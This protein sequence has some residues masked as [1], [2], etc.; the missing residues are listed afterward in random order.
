MLRIVKVKIAHNIQKIN[1]QIKSACN[2]QEKVADL[3]EKM[4][5][6]SQFKPAWWLKSAHAQTILP[7]LM[8]RDIVMDLR[9]ERLSMTDGDFVDLVWAEKGLSQQS[10]LIILLHGLGGNIQ[11][12]YVKGL[13]QQFNRHGWRAVLM[14]FRGCSGVPNR[15][16]RAY[17][18]GETGDFDYL[19]KVLN[20]REPDTIKAAVGI[21]LG[22]NVLLKWLGEKKIQSSI[23]T[24]VAVS[25]PL[26][27]KIAANHMSR[28]FSKFYQNYMIKRLHGIVRQKFKERAHP[29]FDLAGLNDWR[30]FMTF[31]DKVTAPLHGFN[32]VHEYYKKAS[33][34]QYLT[35]IMTP[36]LII[37]AIDDPFMTPE[38]LPDM[39]EISQHTLLEISDNGGHVGFIT[40]TIPGKPEYW[41][42][43]RIPQYLTSCLSL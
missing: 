15:L 16:D 23:K 35:S 5:V 12:S 2:N 9:K 18:S 32:H 33:A 8:R 1:S 26:D 14:H 6:R 25:V 41:L 21:S 4:I 30:C 38:V 19:V 40:G 42:D 7:T 3:E 43:R 28:G 29:P 36:T 24:A 17:H 27:L 13:M 31:D 37:H 20:N 11:S 34:K 39:D 10:P 22:G